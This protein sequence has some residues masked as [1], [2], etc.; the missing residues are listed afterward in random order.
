MPDVQ[1]R[2]VAG[3][4]KPATKLFIVEGAQAPVEYL[5]VPAGRRAS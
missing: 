4:G 3:I 5:L 2:I 1:D